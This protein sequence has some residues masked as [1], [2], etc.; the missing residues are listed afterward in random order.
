MAEPMRQAP[1]AVL[2]APRQSSSRSSATAACGQTAARDRHASES[3][4]RWPW[5]PRSLQ[6]VEANTTP[7]ATTGQ[8]TDSR[9]DWSDSSRDAV[10]AT[11]RDRLP[12][13]LTDEPRC[14]PLMRLGR[15]AQPDRCRGGMQPQRSCRVHAVIVQS[16][17]S[18]DSPITCD[19]TTIIHPDWALWG[20]IA[21][22]PRLAFSLVLE[23]SPRADMFSHRQTRTSADF[24]VRP[25]GPEGLS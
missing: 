12:R 18:G 5:A 13:R 8:L 17:Y 25:G 24:S 14:A 10:D 3:T 11:M 9:T 7:A 21:A 4:T 16:H 1:L 2:A 6:L 22:C 15:R 20:C 19:S 23:R